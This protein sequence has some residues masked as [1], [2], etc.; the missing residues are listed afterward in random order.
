[1][2]REIVE[3]TKLCLADLQPKN[4]PAPTTEDLVGLYNPGG[5]LWEDQKYLIIGFTGE[6]LQGLDPY[7]EVRWYDTQSALIIHLTRE[8]DLPH[9]P[10]L[11]LVLVTKDAEE[12]LVAFYNCQG[13]T[14]HAGTD[15]VN[16]VLRFI[17]RSAR[18]GGSG[19]R[20]PPDPSPVIFFNHDALAG[21]QPNQ[22]S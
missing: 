13:R 4:Q 15:S 12:I 18:L 5:Y 7:D 10:A 14:K 16:D 1:L 6:G 20:T 9:H 21:I 17:L 2:V 11:P 8:S 22:R 3:N 19:Q